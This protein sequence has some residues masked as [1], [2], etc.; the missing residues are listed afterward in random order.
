LVPQFIRAI[1]PLLG[2]CILWW[3]SSRTPDGAPSSFAFSLIHNGMHVVAYACLAGS[4]WLAW[5]R[6]PVA[7]PHRFR[8]RAAWLLALS[9]GAVDEL[10]QSYV[11]GRVCSVFDLASDALGAALAVALLCGVAGLLPQWRLAVAVVFFMSCVSVCLA[12]W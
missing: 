8:S 7:S 1:V 4:I 2:M 3:S 9:Y 6:R 11:P 10:H 12:T 5:S